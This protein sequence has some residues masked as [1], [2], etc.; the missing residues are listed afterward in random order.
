MRK[1]KSISPPMETGFT[2]FDRGKPRRLDVKIAPSGLYIHARGMKGW[3][4]LGWTSIYDRAAATESGFDRA[5]RE[6]RIV[7]G[8]VKKS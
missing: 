1:I 3:R 8:G 4:F 7:R 6:G 5:P 2:V